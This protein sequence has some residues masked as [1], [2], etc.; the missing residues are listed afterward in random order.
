M[1]RFL[2]GNVNRGHASR[3]FKRVNTS[4]NRQMAKIVVLTAAGKLVELLLAKAQNGSNPAENQDQSA[5]S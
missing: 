5:A 3:L 2:T 4:D 1:M